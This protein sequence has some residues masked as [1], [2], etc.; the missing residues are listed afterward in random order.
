MSSTALTRKQLPTSLVDPPSAL[1]P[2]HRWTGAANV[3]MNSDGV[4]D[5][6]VG[7]F[8][9]P[10]LYMITGDD[11]SPG[12]NS[13][14]II[15]AVVSGCLGCLFCLLREARIWV[16]F[17]RSALFTFFVYAGC[18]PFTCTIQNI[19]HPNSH[20][21]LFWA[22]V[23]AT[24]RRDCARCEFQPCLGFQASFSPQP[25]QIVYTSDI[26]SGDDRCLTKGGWYKLR[27]LRV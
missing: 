7:A 25:T 17:V 9:E 16:S 3:D 11:G 4:S 20:S 5:L 1:L 6:L 18:A 26:E 12:D 21:C 27:L 15:L 13:T 10:G 2:F 23:R 24:S 22:R 14:A 8:L 19:D